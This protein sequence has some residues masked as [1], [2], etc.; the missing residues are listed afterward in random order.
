MPWTVE[1][2]L[3]CSKSKNTAP[4]GACL[5]GRAL[6]TFVAGRPVYHYG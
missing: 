2:E 5:E 1:L 4:D 6:V 3:L